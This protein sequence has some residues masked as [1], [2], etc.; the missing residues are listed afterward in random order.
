[1]S[2]VAKLNAIHY[3][4]GIFD[5]FR[6]RDPKNK[7]FFPKTNSFQ[8]PISKI[9]EY[10]FGFYKYLSETKFRHYLRP[11]SEKHFQVIPFLN[12]Q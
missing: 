12:L 9:S 3:H 1:M 5:N 11:A 10:E 7:I 2:K 6:F 8:T 4:S